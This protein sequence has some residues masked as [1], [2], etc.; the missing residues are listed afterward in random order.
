VTKRRL[1]LASTSP[2]RRELLAR[3]G[4]SFVAEP[5][6]VD[7][8]P[9]SGEQPSTLVARLAEAKARAVAARHPDALVIGSDQVAVLDGRA[10]GKPG[11]AAATERQLSSASGRI[12]EFLTGLCLADTRSGRVQVEVVPYRVRFRTL[13]G[14]EIEAYVAR[15][16]PFDCAGG[17][18]AE[19]LGI[20]LFESMEGADPTSLIGLPLIRLCVMLRRAGVDVL[21]DAGSP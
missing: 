11:T 5:P 21:L 18:K 20:S 19:G 10:L 12:V 16:K 4:V 14:A 13:S 2:Y 1:V 8:M 9:L 6:G 3:L 17:F 7:E 15:E